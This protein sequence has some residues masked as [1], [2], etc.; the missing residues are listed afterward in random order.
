MMYL[1]KHGMYELF[2]THAT[3]CLGSKWI[4]KVIKIKYNT[5]KCKISGQ[6]LED[7]EMVFQHENC[8]ETC[9]NCGFTI[10]NKRVGMAFKKLFELD[11]LYDYSTL[12]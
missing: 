1:Q 10:P 11:H 2:L 5:P 9:K 6:Q 12:P 7:F 8:F 3:Q 4:Y